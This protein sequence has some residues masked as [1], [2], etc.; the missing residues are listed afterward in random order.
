MDSLEQFVISME[1]E[2]TFTVR[3]EEQGDRDEGK[4]SQ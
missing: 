2:A 4:Y 3:L 1:P